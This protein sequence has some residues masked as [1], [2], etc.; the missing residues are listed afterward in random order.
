MYSVFSN[1]IP[2]LNP[3]KQCVTTVS[4][5][6]LEFI[7][8]LFCDGKCLPD[9]K[10]CDGTQDCEDDSDE[11]DCQTITPDQCL[12][13]EFYCSD[14][15]IPQLWRCDGQTD[16]DDGNDEDNCLQCPD[17][18]FECGDGSCI[19]YTKVCDGIESC[20]NGKDES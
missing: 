13:S 4:I 8:K 1:L 11:N 17:Q 9:S 3:W 14:Q 2:L 10:L 16:C 19:E 12:G 5:T 15:C 6:N 20:H 18:M 7:V